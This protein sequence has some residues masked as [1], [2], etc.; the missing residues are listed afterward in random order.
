VNRTPKIRAAT[1][2]ISRQREGLGV[3]GGGFAPGADRGDHRPDHLD[4]HALGDLD[5]NLG[6]LDPDDLADNAAGEDD[7]V[8]ALQ[9]GQ[10]RLVLLHPLLLR[11]DQQEVEQDEKADQRSDLQEHRLDPASSGGS[12]GGLGIGRGSEHGLSGR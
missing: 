2:E 3:V 8:I 6:V 9:G 1:T 7:H 11:T 4:G 5:A 10:H 12:G